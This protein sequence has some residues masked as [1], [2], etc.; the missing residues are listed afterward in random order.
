MTLFDIHGNA[1]QTGGGKSKSHVFQHPNRANPT[2]FSIGRVNTTAGGDDVLNTANTGIRTT[3]PI[4]VA[5]GKVVSMGYISAYNHNPFFIATS[6][7]E[8]CLA[9]SFFNSAQKVVSGADNR[10]TVTGGISVPTGATYIRVSFFTDGYNDPVANP[11]KFYVCVEDANVTDPVYWFGNDA[12]TLVAN[13]HQIWEHWGKSWVLFGDSL[14]DSYGGH[15]WDMS[16]SPVGGDGWKETDERVPWT[17]YFWASDIARK[18]GFV[19]DN[20]AKSGSNIYVSRVYTADSGVYQLDAFLS[21]LQAGTVIE[22]DLITIGFGANT[23]PDEIGNP[24]DTSET[25]NTLYGGTKYFIEKLNEFCPNARKV[26][27]LHPLQE[28]WRDTN[29][30]AR[31]AMRNVFNEY[32]VEYVDMSQHSGI[33]VDMLPDKL[34]VSSIEANRQYGRFLERYLY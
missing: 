32:N 1:I 4:P 34:H 24:T 19:M 18:H 25:T 5:A 27:I 6:H 8:W 30:A 11:E 3:A 12:E 29:G 7:T 2:Q 33:T 16:T 10:P 28:D 31:D 21:A 14:T 15:G 17:G 13:D 22:P 26:Y 23:V 9:Y 20:Q